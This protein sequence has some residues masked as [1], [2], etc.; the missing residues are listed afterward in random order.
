MIVDYTMTISDIVPPYGNNYLDTVPI[1]FG[2]D[3]DNPDLTAYNAQLVI[4]QAYA[5]A[6]YPTLWMHVDW[7]MPAIRFDDLVNDLTSDTYAILN[8]T[9][10][11]V[12]DYDALV[13]MQ[14]GHDEYIYQ[15]TVTDNQRYDYALNEDGERDNP[16]GMPG[17]LD[18]FY[19]TL[20]TYEINAPILP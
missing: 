14:V 2:P 4:W 12:W 15:I 13:Q 8:E 7:N 1:D 18:D 5:L 9:I 16:D 19:R 10:E 20:P 11:D 3:N 17:L 6:N